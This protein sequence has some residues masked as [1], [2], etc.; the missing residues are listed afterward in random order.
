MP[1]QSPGFQFVYSISIESKSI[2]CIRYESGLR[3]LA[4]STVD[5]RVRVYNTAEDYARVYTHNPPANTLPC[6]PIV[7]HLQFCETVVNGTEEH[8]VL[9]MGLD[10][11]SVL[12]ISLTNPS[13]LFKPIAARKSPVVDIHL[14]RHRGDHMQLWRRP[15]KSGEEAKYVPSHQTP[16]HLVV[17][18][19]NDVR[20]YKIPEFEMVMQYECPAPI[21][22]YGTI[23]VNVEVQGKMESEYVIAAIDMGSNVL[24]IRLMNLTLVSYAG[25]NNLTRMGVEGISPMST[26]HSCCLL[27]G[28]VVLH[29]DT[30]ETYIVKLLPFTERRALTQ[31]L[32]LEPPK[33]YA[34]KSKGIKGFLGKDKDVNF[35]EVF[36]P[37]KDDP[38]TSSSA[39]SSATPEKSS[40]PAAPRRAA[41]QGQIGEVKGVMADNI[42][43]LNQRGQKLSDM[44]DRSQQMAE[45]SG[46]FA[47][48]ARQLAEQQKKSWF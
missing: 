34:K 22:W 35:E 4:V 18:T 13:R 9:I 11:G 30:F 29:T 31:L 39:S 46:D 19:V 20:T 41:T 43:K 26:P 7:T 36:G 3:L 23:N 45:A 25:P 5:G 28:T 17:C 48:L 12:P 40:A 32:G 27:D 38:I 42:E 6:P 1:T 15:W 44:A 47:S 24:F 10:L 21:A 14:V 8:L 37:R 2:Q 16:K 33:A